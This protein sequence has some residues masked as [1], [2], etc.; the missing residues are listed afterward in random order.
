MIR[1]LTLICASAFAFSGFH[2]YQTKHRA[3]ETDRA[4]V[5]TMKEVTRTHNHAVLLRAEYALLNDPTRLQDLAQQYLAL[6]PTAPTQFVAMADLASRLP[7]V[8]PS[9]NE[10]P[11]A[12]PAELPAPADMPIASAVPPAAAPQAPAAAPAPAPVVVAEAPPPA[13]VHHVAA[14]PAAAHPA[15]VVVAANPPIG[16]VLRSV[17]LIR[18]EPRRDAPTPLH[19]DAA[20]GRQLP[21]APPARLAVREPPRAPA[22]ARPAPVEARYTA[23]AQPR[24]AAP[25][26]GRYAAPTYSGTP[27]AEPRYA[28]PVRPMVGSVLGMAHNAGAYPAGLGR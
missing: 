7:P 12:A 6:R 3:Q 9:P 13:A 26:Q 18:P 23:P 16:S 1:P 25:D 2:L 11:S 20:H 28:A 15:P 17:S 10:A 8:G 14:H 4:I 24:Y 27:F 19:P 22:Y 21:Y 5:Q